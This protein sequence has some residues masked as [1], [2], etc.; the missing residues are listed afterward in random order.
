MKRDISFLALMSL[1]LQ[2]CTGAMEQNISVSDS[3]N[4]HHRVSRIITKLF[5]RVLKIEINEINSFN[6]DGFDCENILFSMDNILSKSQIHS[7]GQS[8]LSDTSDLT[9]LDSMQADKMAPS[10]NMCNNFMI[11][12]LKAKHAQNN[13]SEL[14]INLRKIGHIRETFVGRLFTS[15]CNELGYDEILSPQKTYDADQLSELIFAVGGAEEDGD[16]EKALK[17]LRSFVDAYPGINLESHLSGLSVP[18][19]KYILEQIKSPRKQ[20]PHQSSR[21]LLSNYSSM[22]VPEKAPSFRKMNSESNGENMSMSEKLRYLKSK[23]NAAEET[24]QSVIHSGSNG[25]LPQPPTDRALSPTSNHISTLRQRLASASEKRSS[26]V[27]SPEIQK[28][29]GSEPAAMGN[30]AILRARLETVRRMNGLNIN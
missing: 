2:F 18:F 16:R 28:N 19:R 26:Q 25:D 23:I 21:S 15:C 20:P 17:D 22:S 24:A 7:S 3:N 5:N 29:T 13:L 6:G 1:Q 14:K 30:A 8:V 11:E 9:D 27:R 4:F 12:L 10:R